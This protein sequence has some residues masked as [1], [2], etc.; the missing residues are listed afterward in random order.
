MNTAAMEKLLTYLLSAHTAEELQW[1][2]AQLALHTMPPV[3]PLTRYTMDE[4][5]SILDE[6]EAEF[7][8]GEF[9]TTED[10]LKYCMEDGDELDDDNVQFHREA[11]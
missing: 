7:E 2:T 4:I 5:N 1:L 10:V 8:R 9:Y 11:V 6:S 3:E